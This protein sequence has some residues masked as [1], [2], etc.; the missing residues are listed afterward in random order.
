MPIMANP[1]LPKTG[2]ELKIPILGFFA[3]AERVMARTMSYSN[4]RSRCMTMV[5]MVDFCSPRLTARP[6]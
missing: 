3:L 1:G 4:K 5:D 2:M 6:K